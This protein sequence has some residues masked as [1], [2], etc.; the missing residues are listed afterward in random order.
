MPAYES[1]W[2][3][4]RV[5]IKGGNK[6]EDVWITYD[7]IR[8]DIFTC[9]Q[10]LTKWPARHR[11]QK[12]RKTKNK[13]RFAQKKRCGQK[14]GAGKSPWRQSGRKKWNYGGGRICETSTF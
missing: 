10:K 14:S 4:F 11:N 5:R 13:N 12:L 6:N 3:A 9:A 8:Y 1:H 2:E 7:T